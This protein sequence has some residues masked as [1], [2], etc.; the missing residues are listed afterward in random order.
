MRVRKV[1]NP[2]RI[3]FILIVCKI[4]SFF[5]LRKRL[6]SLKGLKSLKGFRPLSSY[7]NLSNLSKIGFYIDLQGLDFWGV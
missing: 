5:I 6:D 4:C 7:L 1:S 3:I 2:H